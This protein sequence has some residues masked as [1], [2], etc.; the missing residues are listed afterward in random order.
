MSQSHGCWP[1][2]LLEYIVRWPGLHE[3]MK[4]FHTHLPD[5]LLVSLGLLEEN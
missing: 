3:G 2:G 4:N 1:A 5:G